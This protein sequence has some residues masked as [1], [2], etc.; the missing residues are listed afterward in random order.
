MDSGCIRN[1]CIGLL[2]WGVPMSWFGWL[3]GCGFTAMLLMVAS[4]DPMDPGLTLKKALFL[5]VV[6]FAA[7][8]IRLFQVTRGDK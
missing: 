6:L 7:A 2:S 3:A 1:L 4:G 8:G 5:L